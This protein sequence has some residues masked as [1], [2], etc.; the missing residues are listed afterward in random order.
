MLTYNTRAP[1]IVNGKVKKSDHRKQMDA[2]SRDGVSHKDL[3]S[4][5]RREA[6]V[7]PVK[8]IDSSTRLYTPPVP[9]FEVSLTTLPANRPYVVVSRAKRRG[10]CFFAACPVW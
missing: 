6:T 1:V 2:A 4:E 10:C 7:V 3:V 8:G 5:R 9:E